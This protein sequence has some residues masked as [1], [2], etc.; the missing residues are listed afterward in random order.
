MSQI[1]LRNAGMKGQM[2]FVLFTDIDFAQYHA[3]YFI[4]EENRL[5][6]MSRRIWK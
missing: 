1:Q 4:W 3:S 5:Q 6:Q 2:Y